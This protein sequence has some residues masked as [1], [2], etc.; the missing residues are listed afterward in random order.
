MKL[1]ISNQLFQEEIN[2]QKEENHAL[3]EENHSQK[4]KIQ[5]LELLLLTGKKVE[6][7]PHDAVFIE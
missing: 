3:K 4:E 1:F 6:F 7:V 5:Q 2:V